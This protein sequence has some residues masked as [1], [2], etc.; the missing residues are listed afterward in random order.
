M[1]RNLMGYEFGLS[2]IKFFEKLL[3]FLRFDYVY[4]FNLICIL[5]NFFLMLCIF[6]FIVSEFYN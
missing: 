3:F 1:L 2:R 5:K 4:V 6:E